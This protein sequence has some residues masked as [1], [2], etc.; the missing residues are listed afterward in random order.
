MVPRSVDGLWT[1]GSGFQLH[2]GEA[3]PLRFL[4]RPLSGLMLYTLRQM[5][6]DFVHNPI[7]AYVSFRLR[8]RA[9]LLDLAT[10][11]GFFL[12][13]GLGVGTLLE[14]YPLER[15]ATFVLIVAAIFLYEPLMISTYGGTFGHRAF[16]IRVVQG[17]SQNNLT[18]SRSIVRSIVKGLLGLFSF[19]FMFITK[20]S[21][22]LHDLAAGSEVRVRNP[23]T[24]K[25]EDYFV[26]EQLP[27]NRSM[28]SA[29]RRIIVIALY[30][31]FLFVLVSICGASLVSSACIDQDVCTSP[32][33]QA[34]SILGMLLIAVF[35]F[36]IGVGW[37]G[38]LPGCRLQ[39]LL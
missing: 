37:T 33:R 13:A 1:R 31:A 27:A 30:N 39:R 12:I 20:N 34:L 35:V 6:R 7:P 10:C 19:A 29:G 17:K 23:R 36:L 38:R 3:R 2:T 8:F 5:S 14:E 24:A 16:N 15:A 18:L 4:A 11:V 21:Q 28:P 25:P 9:F 22:S 26:P 32:E